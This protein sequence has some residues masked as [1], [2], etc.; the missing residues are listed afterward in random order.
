MTA[1][2]VEYKRQGKNNEYENY[3]NIIKK[4]L[5]IYIKAIGDAN[6]KYMNYID[7]TTPNGHLVRDFL[8]KLYQYTFAFNKIIFYSVPSFPTK[9]IEILEQIQ[10][11]D[12]G[13]ELKRR[14]NVITE[15][16]SLGFNIYRLKHGR[17]TRP[18]PPE[19]SQTNHACMGCAE[20]AEREK[21]FENYRKLIN[22]NESWL[23]SW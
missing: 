23:I 17:D 3:L 16:E 13:V 12:S 8:K 22:E 10:S 2:L 1:T 11:S 19:F 14:S 5:P 21:V 9:L 20:C 15:L 6:A 7:I 18:P 4:E